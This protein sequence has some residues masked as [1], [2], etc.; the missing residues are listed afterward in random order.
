[1]VFWWFQRELKLIN[2]LNFVLKMILKKELI[3][4]PSSYFLLEVSALFLFLSPHMTHKTIMPTEK[5]GAKSSVPWFYRCLVNLQI[6]KMLTAKCKKQNSSHWACLCDHTIASANRLN[7]YEFEIR[8][9][10]TN[11]SPVLHFI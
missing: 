7:C 3:N 11:I 6:S 9:S 4:V 10:L 5:T 1:M 2:V 8:Q